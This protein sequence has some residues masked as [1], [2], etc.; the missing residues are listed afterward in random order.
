MDQKLKQA[1]NYNVDFCGKG[2][3]Y[4]GILI[5]NWVLNAVTLG[6][7]HPWAKEKRLKYLYSETT[8]DGSPFEFHGTGKEMFKGYITSIAVFLGLA[9]I[10]GLIYYA[11]FESIAFLFLVGVILVIVPFAIHGSYRY[12]MSRTSWRGI[13]FGYRGNRKELMVNFL[14][15]FGLTAITFGIYGS[16]FTINLRKYTLQNIRLGNIKMEYEGNGGDYL[17]LNIKGYFLTLFTLGI[18]GFWWQKEIIEYYINNLKMY[19]DEDELKISTN[20]TG[21]ELLK[22]AIVNLLIITFTFGIGTAWVEMRI[23][24]FL[25]SSIQLEGTID[26]STIN[27]TEEIYKDATGEDMEDMLD[28]DLVI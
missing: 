21:G 5:L 8:L 28:M 4:F 27:Q 1:K 14:K 26:L 15:W 16:W 10:F 11:G 22:V 19:K 17:I 9:V 6:F 7:Y 25:L 2:E 3:T 20:I 12:R 24:K 13:R 18:Y 23:M